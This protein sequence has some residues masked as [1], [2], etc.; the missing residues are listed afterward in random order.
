MGPGRLRKAAGQVRSVSQPGFYP[1]RGHP[2][3]DHADFWHGILAQYAGRLHRLYATKRDV[4]V[5]DYVDENEPILAK[6]ATRREAGYRSLGYRT[7]PNSDVGSDRF[8][9]GPWQRP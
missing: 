5:F 4:V 6:M 8:H 9:G 3:P 7:V 1:G 2:V